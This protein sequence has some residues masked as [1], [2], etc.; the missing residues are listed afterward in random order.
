MRPPARVPRL[1][2]SIIL[3]DR[4]SFVQ[5]S[6]VTI[7]GLNVGVVPRGKHYRLGVGGYTLRRNYS[8]LYTY[9]YSGKNKVRKLKDTL[10]PALSLRERGKRGS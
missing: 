8:E 9:T 2:L 6:A 1:G 3:D 7:I 5:S 10:T 4:D